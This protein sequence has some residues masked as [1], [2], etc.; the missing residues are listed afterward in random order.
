MLLY[1]LDEIGPNDLGSGGNPTAAF[2]TQI[3][4]F[5]HLIPVG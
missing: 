5:N 3:K 1:R 2:A 4:T